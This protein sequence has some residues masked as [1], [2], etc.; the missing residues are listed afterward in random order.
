MLTRGST[1]EECGVFLSEEFPYL[2][3]SPDGVICIDNKRFGVIKVKY[4]FTLQKL[5]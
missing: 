1:V 5:Y 4:P 3:T 2:A